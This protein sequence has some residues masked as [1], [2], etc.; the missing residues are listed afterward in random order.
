MLGLKINHV[1][2]IAPGGIYEAVNWIVI[3]SDNDFNV[4]C[5]MLAIL[6]RP[7]WAK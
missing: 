4:I 1:S 6:F 2:K 7:K 3:D 5:K